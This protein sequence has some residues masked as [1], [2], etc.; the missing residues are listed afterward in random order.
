MF[1]SAAAINFP[2]SGKLIGKQ[3]GYGWRN[4]SGEGRACETKKIYTLYLL[5]IN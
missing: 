1:D 2:V 5:L 3:I 4:H